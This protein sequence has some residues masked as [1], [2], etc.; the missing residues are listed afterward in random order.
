MLEVLGA[1]RSSARRSPCDKTKHVQQQAAPPSAS[2]SS[3]TATGAQLCK[4]RSA[5]KLP[6]V[7]EH[8]D[9][10]PRR[11]G[12]STPKPAARAAPAIVAAASPN[13]RNVGRARQSPPAPP[14]LLDL[15]PSALL[16]PERADAR[17]EGALS[18]IHI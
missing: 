6:R 16:P 5:I 9:A 4:P 18:L 12:W 15:G 7:V 3:V 11:S 2:A 1:R 17:A 8:G 14:S 10:P 13:D